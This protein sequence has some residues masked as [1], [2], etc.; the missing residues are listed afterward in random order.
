MSAVSTSTTPAVKRRKMGVVTQSPVHEKVATVA[1]LGDVGSFS[2]TAASG[3][4]R[5]AFSVVT[6]SSVGEVCDAV[7]SGTADRGVIPV[8][9]SY[10]GTFDGSYDALLQYSTQL[11]IVNEVVKEESHAL[12][13]RAGVAIDSVRRV[14]AH[15]AAFQQCSTLVNS[16]DSKVAAS[17]SGAEWVHRE[18]AR[19]TSSACR[20]VASGSEPSAAIAT[21]AAAAAHG[22]VVLSDGISNDRNNQTRFVVV[23]KSAAGAAAS[24]PHGYL[25]KT[26]VAIALRN[27]PAAIFKC[28]S[29][30]ALREINVAKVFSRP[31]SCASADFVPTKVHWDYIVYIDLDGSSADPA[32]AA[33]LSNLREFVLTLRVLGSYTKGTTRTVQVHERFTASSISDLLCGGAI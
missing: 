30:F 12:C 9:N 5:E 13:S 15:P 25:A 10:V 6:C 17:S 23:A 7:A 24:P 8:E 18:L 31:M 16:L 3:F 14:F 28:L 21:P 1:M 29:C 11:Q 33:A 22:L 19:S 4:F 26:S 2:H 27:E 32:M 20:S